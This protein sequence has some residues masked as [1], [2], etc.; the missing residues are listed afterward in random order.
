MAKKFKVQFQPS[1]VD[2]LDRLYQ[3]ISFDKPNAARKFISVL[4]KK[5]FDLA[6]FPR[7]GALCRFPGSVGK[8]VRFIS[9]KGYL[10]FY[11][12]TDL[13]VIVLHLTGPG[14]NWL[15]LFV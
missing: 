2:D 3:F 6:Y 5:V 8:E 13:K 9:H 14:K 15:A 12:L 10:I 4:K 11:T 1:A 7:R